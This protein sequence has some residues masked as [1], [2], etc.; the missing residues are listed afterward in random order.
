MD[1]S[2]GHD[3]SSF[4]LGKELKGTD[5]GI[6]ADAAFFDILSNSL[7]AN[8]LLAVLRETITN[9]M[10]ANKENRK[11]TPVE[12]SFTEDS[13]LLS[14][15]DHGKGIPH[16]KVHEIYCVYGTTT[17]KET[18]STGGFGLGCKSPFAL[19]DS[20]T[21]SNCYQGIRKDYLLIKEQ[22]IPKLIETKGQRNDDN[23]GLTVNILLSRDKYVY[24]RICEI[25]TS[26]CFCGGIK[27]QLNGND[28]SYVQ[29]PENRVTYLGKTD[30]NVKLVDI[31][32]SDIGADTYVVKYGCNVYGFNSYAL[33][34]EEVELKEILEEYHGY[35]RLGI[36][37]GYKVKNGVFFNQYIPVFNVPTN[38]IDIT[39][40]RENIRFTKKTVNTLIRIVKEEISH[41]ENSKLDAKK[42]IK[43]FELDKFQFIS[44]VFGLRG[45][46]NKGFTAEEINWHYSPAELLARAYQEA[47]SGIEK[48]FASY[49]LENALDTSQEKRAKLA[50]LLN[51]LGSPL[52]ESLRKT[53]IYNSKTLGESLE[54]R[55]KRITESIEKI[56]ERGDTL[57]ALLENLFKIV[58]I[59][60]GK[61]YDTRSCGSSY[62]KWRRAAR[63]KE[64]IN[65]FFYPYDYDYIKC[66]SYEIYCKSASKAAQLEKELTEKGYY[67]IN[68]LETEG[69][70][71]K[72]S[73]R[74]TE[75]REVKELAK[76]N[77][78]YYISKEEWKAFNDC[79][80]DYFTLNMCY[81]ERVFPE[82]A[83][84]SLRRVNDF[85]F[86]MLE[87]KTGMDMANKLELKTFATVLSADVK[88]ILEKDSKVRTALGLLYYTRRIDKYRVDIQFDLSQLIWLCL[89][90]PEFCE[91]YRLPVLDKS[92]LGDICLVLSAIDQ[93][94]AVQE[95]FKEVC[96]YKGRV[97]RVCDTLNTLGNRRG[98][99]GLI[100]FIGDILT[101]M[102]SVD[103]DSM[104]G[105]LLMNFLDTLFGK[106][107]EEDE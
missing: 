76:I 57:N 52:R 50:E 15:T 41:I 82:G 70:R 51:E 48:E 60:T 31:G 103:K 105:K 78:S 99:S 81:R 86:V 49:V 25:I 39:P 66:R 10:D 5:F 46:E 3:I 24:K 8:P 38:S 74:V 26:L 16:D 12:I 62:A 45:K 73:K 42:V 68:L 43:E 98:F 107:V 96:P 53:K 65:A 40:N 20:F 94:K 35:L 58:I 64:Q 36:M 104:E 75:P 30:N 92:Q 17:K 83:Y 32:I 33:P 100:L 21:I 59:S 90:V 2:T 34:K 29:Y 37:R 102:E 79:K 87:T 89:Q 44:N 71:N 18:D 95:T 1:L 6:N 13:F 69:I 77:N 84:S 14:V 11:D 56:Q 63:M 28:L 22:G 88:E 91:R 19:V 93:Y 54:E 4:V 97:G 101:R 27:A 106:G 9:A 47:G 55:M 80:R 23:T 7:Y 67:V 85:Y 72:P 61:S